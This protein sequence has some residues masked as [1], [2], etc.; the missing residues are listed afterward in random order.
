MVVGYGSPPVY[1][2]HVP[3]QYTWCFASTGRGSKTYTTQ[4]LVRWAVTMTARGTDMR[5]VNDNRNVAYLNGNSSNRNLNL[6]R[7]NDNWN[8]NYSFAAVRNSIRWQAVCASR[9][10]FF[11]SR[12]RALTV[13][14]IFYCRSPWLARQFLGKTS[15]YRAWYWHDRP[16]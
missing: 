5:Q 14:Y 3:Q 12:R 13:G 7:W 9:R 16:R 15:P 1:R 11:R 6:N 8:D 10:A 2:R 4:R